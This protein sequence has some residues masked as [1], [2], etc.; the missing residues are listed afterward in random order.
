MQIL[1]L[2]FDLL[3]LRPFYKLMDIYVHMSP[4]KFADV[5]AGHTLSQEKLDEI[6]AFRNE[7]YQEK[8]NYLIA[9]DEES[10]NIEKELDRRSYHAIAYNKQKE[11]VAVTRLTPYPFE[12]TTILGEGKTS[13]FKR[14]LEISRL[15]AKN[16]NSGIGRRLLIKSGCFAIR[17]KCYDGFIAICRDENYTVFQKFGL[18]KI[19][20]F[21]YEQ[22]FDANYHFIC[23][24]FLKV[25]TST[26]K[27]FQTRLGHKI[28][29]IF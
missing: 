13:P 25:S 14:Y 3:I 17:S 23:A 24:N 12:L 5:L 19:E 7:M 11:I 18:N 8:Q 9:K 10:R 26:I 28:S 4:Y 16:K 22:R 29:T 6:E 1:L 20:T 21:K 27:Y 15:V 2:I